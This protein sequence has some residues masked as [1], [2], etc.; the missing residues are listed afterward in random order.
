MKL[1]CKYTYEYT[2]NLSYIFFINIHINFVAI[3]FQAFP[4]F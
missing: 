4:K 1:Y 3:L 2:F